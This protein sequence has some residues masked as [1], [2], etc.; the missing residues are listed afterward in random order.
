MT[1]RT[2]L[3]SYPKSG[4]TWLRFVA[5]HLTHGRLPR[6]SVELDRFINSALPPRD[7]ETF[8]KSHAASGALAPSLGAHDRVIYIVRHPLD[9]FQS[10]LNY[11][12]LNGEVAESDLS[13]WMARYAARGGHPPWERAPY[14]AGT[15]A[16]NVRSWRDHSAHPVLWISYEE[17]LHDLEAVARRVAGFIGALSDD[18]SIAACVNDTSFAALRSFE[19]RE[20]DAAAGA[21]APQ[22][23]FSSPERLKAAGDG[24]RF[25]N[26]GSIGSWRDVIPRPVAEAAWAVL[27]PVAFDLGYRLDV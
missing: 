17:S 27:E 24:V 6:D 15:W 9:V 19:Q 20:L 2:W 25:F 3:V 14:S 16:D 22:G 21:G 26:R 23:R 7:G 13:D 10:A 1:A 18:D 11:A 4:N 12:W 5:F 8:K